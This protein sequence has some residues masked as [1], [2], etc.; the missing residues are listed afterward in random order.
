MACDEP[1][2]ELAS[3]NM[4]ATHDNPRGTDGPNEN[5]RSGASMLPRGSNPG[6][7]PVLILGTLAA[8]AISVVTM[9]F[10]LDLAQSQSGITLLVAGILLLCVLTITLACV[11]SLVRRPSIDFTKLAPD[12]SKLGTLGLG[13]TKAAVRD[14]FLRLSKEAESIEADID[15]EPV[16]ARPLATAGELS[17]ALT[18][19]HVRESGPQLGKQRAGPR[20]GRPAP[21]VAIGPRD[22]SSPSA[23]VVRKPVPRRGRPRER[24]GPGVPPDGD[25]RASKASSS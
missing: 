17:A 11:T 9:S 5:D 25:R 8:L 22:R 1:D 7:L 13:A 4:T 19:T 2:L 23:S 18:G 14:L 15:T 24:T 20:R 10:I 6:P 12:F 21:V 3:R 16:N